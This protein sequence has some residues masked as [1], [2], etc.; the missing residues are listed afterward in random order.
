MKTLLALAL[1]ALPLTGQWLT[2]GPSS[3]TE[4]S[5]IQ[6]TAIGPP[7]ATVKV[8]SVGNLAG[9]G[10]PYNE[11][12]LPRN[13]SA[14]EWA[15]GFYIVTILVRPRQPLLFSWGLLT[16]FYHASGNGTNRIKVT[17]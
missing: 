11:T 10:I 15:P 8:W 4:L 13:V 17:S 16:V 3:T 9:S 12:L 1:L 2:W 14:V 7:G 5:T 6:V